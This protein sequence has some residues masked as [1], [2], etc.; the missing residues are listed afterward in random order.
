VILQQRDFV[1]MVSHELR[2]LLALVDANA[3]RFVTLRERLTAPEVAERALRIRDAVRRMTGL[4][5]N[6][7]APARLLDNQGN[8]HFHEEPV[9]V[10]ALLCQACQLQRDLTPDAPIIET[11]ESQSLLVPGDA[12][13]LRQVFGNILSNAVK[14]SPL[15]TGVDVVVT[16]T[17]DEVIVVIEDRGMGIP[18]EELSR[19]FEHS[20]RASNTAGMAGSGM[21]LYVAKTLVDLHQGSIGVASREGSGSRFEIHLP[22]GQQV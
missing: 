15:R 19:I 17:E 6:L 1:S 3:Q 10:T 12:T 22:R 9:D 7:T 14:Y 20:F 4:I 5:D 21:G 2:G 13:L 18:E 8:V 16:S 11:G